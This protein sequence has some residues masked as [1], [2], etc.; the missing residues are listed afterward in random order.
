MLFCVL[1]SF[2]AADPDVSVA[3]CSAQRKGAF[4]V[5]F[6]D[7]ATAPEPRF[8]IVLRATGRLTDIDNRGIKDGNLKNILSAFSAEDPTKPL[9]IQL[10]IADGEETR[11]DTLLSAI[12]RIKSHADPRLETRVIINVRAK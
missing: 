8:K 7:A 9:V 12:S 3:T 10:I 2:C 11:V 4:V 1:A 5:E 6:A